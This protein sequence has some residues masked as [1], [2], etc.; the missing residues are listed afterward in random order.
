MA[1][2]NNKKGFESNQKEIILKKMKAYKDLKGQYHV[3][4]LHFVKIQNK[5]KKQKRILNTK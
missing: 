5:S 2:W 4:K 1:N 3:I